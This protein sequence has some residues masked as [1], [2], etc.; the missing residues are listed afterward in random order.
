MLRDVLGITK[1][2]KL[3]KFLEDGEHRGRSV[4]RILCA[5]IFLR[6]FIKQQSISQIEAELWR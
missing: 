2:W 1:D 5:E 6:R 4:C 3:I